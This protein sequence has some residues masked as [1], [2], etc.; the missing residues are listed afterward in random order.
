M[1]NKRKMDTHNFAPSCCTGYP[2][3]RVENGQKISLFSVPKEEERPKDCKSKQKDKPLAETS[4]V[5]E[6][7]FAEHFVICDYVHVIGGNEVRIPR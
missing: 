2:G 6:K 4:V 1:K 5:C 7:H 3:H